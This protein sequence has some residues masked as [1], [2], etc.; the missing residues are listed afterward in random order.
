MVGTCDV[1]P[2]G[3]GLTADV[4]P[5]GVRDFLPVGVIPRLIGLNGDDDN[6]TGVGGVFGRTGVFVFVIG[7]FVFV[8]GDFTRGGTGEPARCLMGTGTLITLPFL[9]LSFVFLL[10]GVFTLWTG[11]F[12]RT[13]GIFTLWTGD[14]VRT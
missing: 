8:I 12:V 11:D 7:D 14:F 10:V 9:S 1:L 2:V 4:L 5:V 6:F 13:G 3:I